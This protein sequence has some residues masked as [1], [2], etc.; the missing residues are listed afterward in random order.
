MCSNPL[1]P[2]SFKSRFPGRSTNSS[3][4]QARHLN[5]ELQRPEPWSRG[6]S[7]TAQ[8]R[9]QPARPHPLGL[10]EVGIPAGLPGGPVRNTC[11]AMRVGGG[12]GCG[13]GSSPGWGRYSAQVRTRVAS[14][15]PPTAC[16]RPRPQ[17]V[18]RPEAP[19]SR[20]RMRLLPRPRSAPA[21]ST[22]S[23]SASAAAVPKSRAGCAV[24]KFHPGFRAFVGYLQR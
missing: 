21:Y 22:L 1:G 20:P 24:S 8:G 3:D 14:Q 2:T 5:W 11:R 17:A 19:P 13:Q 6:P 10:S 23:I 18:L 9:R 16:R 15:D 4:Y 7:P 12:R